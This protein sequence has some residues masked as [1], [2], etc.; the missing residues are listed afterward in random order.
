L[1][2]LT[3]PPLR[4]AVEMAVWD[5]L[6]KVL[7]QPLCNLLGGYYRR[8]IPVTYRL[9]G[10]HSKSAPHISRELAEQ[11]FHTQT[12]A[13][14]GKPEEDRKTLAAIR[15]MV[16]DRIELRMDGLGLYDMETA[17]NL[18]TDI[19][20]ERMQF[21]LDPLRV[22]ELHPMSSLGRQTSV[23]LAAWKAIHGS[24]DVLAAVRC[25]A[26]P[27][28]LIDLEQV[29]GVMPARACA[30]VAEAA[31]VLPVLGCR[32]SVGIA[33]AA[34]LHIAAAIPAFS[35]SNELACR[36]IHDTVLCEPLEITDGMVTV[37]QSPG[38]GVEVDR[39]KV[40]RYQ[41]KS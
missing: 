21:V 38:L 27:F 30:S 16:G 2:V 23:P 5:L 15:E 9:E 39:A 13:A 26:A 41:A 6:G 36:Q 20:S 29:G 7:D 31:D 3:P 8:R 1:D 17:R 24:A 4:S 14:S 37:P 28:L 32:S 40:E 12:I 34:Q 10:C 25:G 22:S 35:T 11:G 19:E 18:C 33:T